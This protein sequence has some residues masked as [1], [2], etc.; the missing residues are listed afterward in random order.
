MKGDMEIT[1]EPSLGSK[2]AA[3]TAREQKRIGDEKVEER[4]LNGIASMVSPAQTELDVVPRLADLLDEIEHLILRV[5]RLPNVAFAM[6]IALWI[7]E[8]YTFERFRYCGYLALR[9]ATPRRGKT[10]LMRIL[11]QLANG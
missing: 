8:T 2:L 6:F 7:V 4:F 3:I 1:P 5:V 9:S 11:S 10:L